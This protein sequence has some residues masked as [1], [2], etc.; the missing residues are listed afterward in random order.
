MY[1]NVTQSKGIYVTHMD[2][3]AKSQKSNKIL[4]KLISEVI[5]TSY[6]HF[7]WIYN[8]INVLI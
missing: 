7:K 3:L 5:Q 2:V 1:K 8:I 6:E 4:K